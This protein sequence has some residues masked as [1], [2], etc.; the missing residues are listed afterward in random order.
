MPMLAKIY[1]S[2]SKVDDNEDG[3][4]T[5]HGIASSE[6]KDHSGETVLADA[7]KAALPAYSQFPALRE[8][9][10]PMAAGKV[11][12][13]EVD[14][15]GVTHIAALVVDPIAIQK[16][17]TGVYLGFS[18]GGKVLKRDPQ[19]RSI[20]TAL[21]LVEI[22]LVDSPCNPDA[23]LS[24][25]KA[26]AMTIETPSRDE[27]IARAKD[28]AKA[29]GTAR[30]RDFLFDAREAIV[31]ERTLEAVEK[32]E[33]EL[34]PPAEQLAEA[35]TVE[36]VAD[37]EQPGA[38]VEAPA[39]A[40]AV[41]EAE[42]PAGDAQPGEAETVE[43]AATGDEVSGQ[44]PGDGEE[45][46]GEGDQ[47]PAAEEPKEASA[48][49]A[50][51]TASIEKGQALV[52]GAAP[53]EAEAPADPFADLGKAAAALRIISVGDEDLAKGLYSVSRF[54][55]LLESFCYLASSAQCEA[56]CEGDQS[57]VPAKLADAVRGLGAIL[58]EMAQ[59]EVAE[60]L[61]CLPGG[62]EIIYL[63]DGVEADSVELAGQIVDLVKAN[64]PLLEKMAGATLA[65]RGPAGEEDLDKANARVVE[66]EGEVTTLTTA[67]GQAGESVEKMV[68]GFEQTVAGLTGQI[69]DLTKRFEEI[70]QTPIPPKTA[71]PAA[72]KVVQKGQDSTGLGGQGGGAGGEGIGAL[73]PE[74]FQKAWDGLT[75]S[76]RGEILL[77]VALSNPQAVN[78]R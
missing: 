63:A 68:T 41:V 58:V 52:E 6:T 62:V 5:V 54:A 38:V 3:T 13:A 50:A 22:S 56:D 18:I 46:P 43:A 14:E 26:E 77:K 69:E 57:P 64:A 9:H 24:M 42:A 16:V 34:A 21:R 27:V 61:A 45:G 23:T 20:I 39:S 73:S 4:I 51:L 33:I 71:G 75:P 11:V 31:S 59:E 78:P 66:L 8:M 15:M 74:Q 76:E 10:Q 2:I 25:W 55:D 30:Y 1:G 29:A 48:L 32:G 36:A 53:A 60:M 28:L 47:D 37:V 7:M 17:K 70:D 19:D 12:E 35:E 40:E 44:D 65:K 67:L 49:V 72:T